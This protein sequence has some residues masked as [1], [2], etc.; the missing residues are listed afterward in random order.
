MENFECENKDLKK[1]IHKK[2]KAIKAMMKESKDGNHK[3]GKVIKQL[4]NNIE[5]HVAS[6]VSE[7]SDEMN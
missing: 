4:E 3:Y 5:E 2:N 7:L 6:K 1:E